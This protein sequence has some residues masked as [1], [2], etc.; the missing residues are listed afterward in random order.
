MSRQNIATTNTVSEITNFVEQEQQ[1]IINKFG[2]K[3]PKEKRTLLRT[4]KLM[5]EMGELCN[6]I[7][8]LENEQRKDKENISSVGLEMADIFI[9]LLLLAKNLNIDL[10]AA[11]QQKI[12]ILKERYKE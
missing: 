10:F 8:Y 4:V 6:Q 7:L 5:E 2:A 11:T 9:V 1:R 12:N 3:L